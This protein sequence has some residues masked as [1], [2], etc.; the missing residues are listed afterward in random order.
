MLT[1]CVD[2]RPKCRLEIVRR[3]NLGDHQLDGQGGSGGLEFGP[4][5][6]NAGI[7]SV[8]QKADF[9]CTRHRIQRNLQLLSPEPFQIHQDAGDIAGRPRIAADQ[10]ETVR[11]NGDNNRNGRRCARRRLRRRRGLHQDHVGLEANQFIGKS[12]EP[13]QKAVGIS[14]RKAEVDALAPAQIKKALKECGSIAF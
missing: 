12:G 3:M 1:L 4:L 9:R 13:L 11:H 6:C 2:K 10:S 14:L 8:E 7:C 5:K